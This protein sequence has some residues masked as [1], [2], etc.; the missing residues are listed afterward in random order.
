MMIRGLMSRRDAASYRDPVPSEGRPPLL[1][2]LRTR[3]W[4]AIDAVLVTVPFASSMLDSSWAAEAR[5]PYWLALVLTAGAMLPLAVRRIWPLPVAGVVVVCSTASMLASG[6]RYPAFEVSLACYMVAVQRPTR[7]A[8]A[9]LVVALVAVASAVVLSPP[10]AGTGSAPGL[11]V[12]N[13]VLIAVAWALG[14]QVRAQRRYAA[15]LRELSAR[16]AV[17]RERLRI[18]RELHDVVAHGMSLIAVQASVANYVV[19]ERPDEAR[20]VLGS[21]E[22]ASRSGLQELRHMLD[23]L[24]TG[25]DE[26]DRVRRPETGLDGLDA[27]AAR[28]RRA[29]LPVQIRVTGARRPLPLA[30]DLSLYRIA[31]EALTN[32]VKHAGPATAEVGI[33]FRPD[34][35]CLTVTDDGRGAAVPAGAAHATVGAAGGAGARVAGDDAR[36]AGDGVPV[37]DGHG[38]A[39]MRERVALFGGSLTA[40]PVPPPATG[41]QVVAWLPLAEV[42]T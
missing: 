16:E 39:G 9:V 12:T 18:A 13:V 15:R 14:F 37:R 38:I 27:L 42:A 41:F 40:G 29:G 10:T 31:Q 22:E 7:R 32:V 1:S 36:V 19:N 24:R 3:H 4:V 20:R 33:D 8:L 34:G 35:V 17:G 25:E 2:R 6:A 23:V 11:L 21:I 5:V 28:F 30:A 26:P